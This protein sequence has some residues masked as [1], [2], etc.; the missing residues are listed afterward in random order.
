MSEWTT[1]G[2][3]KAGNYYLR[4][5]G[6]PDIIRRVRVVTSLEGDPTS[7]W[8]EWANVEFYGDGTCEPFELGSFVSD[9]FEWHYEGPVIGYLDTI[10][11][12]AALRLMSLEM[13]VPADERRW[14]ESS[15]TALGPALGRAISAVTVAC[16][17]V[18]IPDPE[19]RGGW[20]FA[21]LRKN[22]GEMARV[23]IASADEERLVSWEQIRLPWRHADDR[24]DQ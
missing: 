5:V 12:Q 6:E 17:P 4:K 15:P 16:D 14:T 20:R 8:P 3:D 24:Y 11:I 2:P 18:L 9:K 1:K 7:E 19:A 22:E 10:A 23:Y 13:L 21:D